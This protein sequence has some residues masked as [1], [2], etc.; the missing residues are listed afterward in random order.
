MGVT[1]GGDIRLIDS[2][3]EVRD[4]QIE[5]SIQMDELL[6]LSAMGW[7]MIAF[8]A[9]VGMIILVG[10]ELWRT[11]FAAHCAGYMITSGSAML[12]LGIIIN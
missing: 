10:I 5:R 1:L 4:G 8:L 6:L 12:T 11:G 2:I 7:F 9:A 3:N